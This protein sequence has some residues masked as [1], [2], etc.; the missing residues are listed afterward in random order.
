MLA[1][2]LAA[3]ACAFACALAF[4]ILAFLAWA[5]ALAWALA[6]FASALA[7]SALALAALACIDATRLVTLSERGKA[8]GERR[9]ERRVRWAHE[10]GDLLLRSEKPAVARVMRI[11]AEEGKEARGEG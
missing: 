3:L 11:L 4:A 9:G 7:A 10:A 6:I 1:Y 8:R 5:C 2:A